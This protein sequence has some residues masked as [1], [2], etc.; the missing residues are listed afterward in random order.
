M[1]KWYKYQSKARPNFSRWP[2][3]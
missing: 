3:E 2:I 1:S